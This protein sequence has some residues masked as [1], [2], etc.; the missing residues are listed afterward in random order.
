MVIPNEL[1]YVYPTI[2]KHTFGLC[3]EAIRQIQQAGT[4][5]GGRCHLAPFPEIFDELVSATSL[6]SFPTTDVHLIKQQPCL[7]TPFTSLV[8]S[9]GNTWKRNERKV[10]CH[11]CFLTGLVWPRHDSLSVLCSL[12]LLGS[13]SLLLTV[14]SHPPRLLVAYDSKPFTMQDF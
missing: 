13:E 10:S 11:A 3:F 1:N 2:S 4:N 5:P 8:P 9:I 12:S 6:A 14:P 7:D